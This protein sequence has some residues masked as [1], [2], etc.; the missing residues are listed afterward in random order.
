MGS[1]QCKDADGNEQLINTVS[2]SDDTYENLETY[3]NQEY[4]EDKFDEETTL[5]IENKNALH[6]SETS[7]TQVDGQFRS[8]NTLLWKDIRSI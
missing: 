3:F 4:N 7:L 5:S 2:I 8:G 6:I 1:E